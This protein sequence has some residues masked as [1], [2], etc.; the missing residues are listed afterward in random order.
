MIYRYVWHSL[1]RALPDPIP[2]VSHALPAA[3]NL[4]LYLFFYI[5]AGPA[6]FDG[7]APLFVLLVEWAKIL[8]GFIY[9]ALII[10]LLRRN[11][12]GLREWAAP[13]ERRRWIVTLVASFL[14]NWIIVLV[15]ATLLWS[16]RVS[17]DLRIIITGIQL[18]A[19]LD[20]KEIR[21]AIRDRLN[22]PPGFVEETLH[23]LERFKE[24]RRYTNPDVTLPTLAERVG[25]H[26][27]ALSYIINEEMGMG[28]REYL[29]RLRLHEFLRLAFDA[30]F[31][32]KSTF[33]RAFREHYGTTPSDYL[34]KR[35]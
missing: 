10:R 9:T 28:F 16:T 24:E 22:L 1:F 6:A 8:S 4:L 25:V 27:N 33:L 23:R 14:A 17:A 7:N 19:V 30:G 29:N 11:I 2:F 3:I 5:V 13:V 21:A 20:P 12:S 18:L 15:A 35:P 34:A 26:P 32:S 31:S